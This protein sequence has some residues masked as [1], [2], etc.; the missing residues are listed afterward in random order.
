MTI[1]SVSG[2]ARTSLA[3]HG[4]ILER[5][6]ISLKTGKLMVLTSLFMMTM[7]DLDLLISKGGKITY[8]IILEEIMMIMIMI[9]ILRTQSQW[10]RWINS[11][12][13]A[14]FLMQY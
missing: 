1:R 7:T 8:K 13:L 6:V 10:N 9:I 4:N 12:I 3:I 14:T 11:A 2:V 5:P